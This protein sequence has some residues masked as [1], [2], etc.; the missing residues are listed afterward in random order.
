MSPQLSIFLCLFLSTILCQEDY[1]DPRVVIVGATGVGKSSLAD[2]LLGCDPRAGGCMFNVCGDTNSC[3]NQTSIGIGPWLGTGQD[4]TVVDTPG[5]GD[6]SGNDNQYIQEMMDILDNKLGYAHIILLV[7]E[8]STPRFSSGLED[9][10]KQMSSIFGETWWEYM[11]IGVSKWPY[12]QDS[13]DKRQEECDYYGDP[14][15]QCHNE[16]WFIREFNQQL[17]ERFDLSKNFTFAFMDSF[18]QAGPNLEDI[19]Q[20]EHWLEETDKL[21][22]EATSK[23]STFDFLT[24]DDVLEQ[25]AE[26]K[27]ENKRLHDIIDD[28]ITALYDGLNSVSKQANETDMRVDAVELDLEDMGEKVDKL[29]EFPIGSIIPWVMRL[30]DADDFA[31]LPEG[32]V[33]CDG[34]TVPHGS[35]WAGLTT[36]DLN[37]QNLFLRGGD[38]SQVLEMESDQIEDHE[39]IDGEHYHSCSATSSAK[40]HSH[41]YEDYGY[42][43][44]EVDCGGNC[45][46]RYSHNLREADDMESVEVQ[47]DTDCS[48]TGTGS[49]MGGVT[50][51]SKSGTETRPANM[52]VVYIIRIF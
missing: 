17:Q 39:H 47:V 3:T 51:S 10:L 40:P 37:G 11:M 9:M 46:S 7:L 15:D 44:D 22:T 35:I 8:G 32:W 18:S 2:A 29:A 28:N 45:Y 19:V 12:D 16:A 30:E 27:Q 20:Q 21:W 36:P 5:F 1:P 43:L 31:E 6:S 25:N 41:Q 23:N 34:T 33:K 48:T 13:I 26:C 49:N 50:S 42:Y 52:K 38:D 24:I 4:Y 14:S